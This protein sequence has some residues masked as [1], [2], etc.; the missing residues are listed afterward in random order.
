MKMK[1]A[2][3]GLDGTLF[4]TEEIHYKAFMSVILDDNDL[5]EKVHDK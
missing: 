4:D 2:I 1:L 5:I 3:F